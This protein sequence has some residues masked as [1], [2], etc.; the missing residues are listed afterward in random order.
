M[1]LKGERKNQQAG[2]MGG[3]GGG[4]RVKD[5][6]Q[7]SG[8]GGAWPPGRA[9]WAPSRAF[10]PKPAF[11]EPPA[12]QTLRR[13]SGLTCYVGALREHVARHLGTGH[14]SLGRRA[15]SWAR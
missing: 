7:P 2:V 4:V 9:P 5:D 13:P 1:Q 14:C 6:I 15:C 10:L 11:A 12:R 8:V 3:S